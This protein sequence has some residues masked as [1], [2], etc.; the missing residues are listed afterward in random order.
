M[1]SDYENLLVLWANASST[2][3]KKEEITMVELTWRIKMLRQQGPKA[4]GMWTPRMVV[5][6]RSSADASASTPGSDAA[7]ILPFAWAT[8]EFDRGPCL[9]ELCSKER[10]TVLKEVPRFG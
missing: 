9:T 8:C 7:P 5:K 3:R 10:K 4:R 6:S 2:G 1:V